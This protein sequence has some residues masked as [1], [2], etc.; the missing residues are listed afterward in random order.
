M[1]QCLRQWIGEKFKK[2]DDILNACFKKMI[3]TDVELANGVARLGLWANLSFVAGLFLTLH[4][5][6]IQI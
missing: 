2:F 5:V 6:C 4:W 1:R 3:S